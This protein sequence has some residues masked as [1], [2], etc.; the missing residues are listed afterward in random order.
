MFTLVGNKFDMT[1]VSNSSR[2]GAQ[3]DQ[4]D[5]FA[6]CVDKKGNIAPSIAQLPVESKTTK[7]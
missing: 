2:L 6:D 4:P 1:L 7:N 5:I 3:V